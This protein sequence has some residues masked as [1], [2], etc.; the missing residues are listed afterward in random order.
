MLPK[1]NKLDFTGQTIYA[2]L[3]VHNKDFKVTILGENLSH[4][5]FTQPPKANVLANYLQK[6]FPGA[7]YYAAYE[8]GFSGFWLQEQLTSYGINCIVVNPAD[9]PTTDKEKKQKQDK[10]DSRKIARSLRNNDLE[11]IYVPSKEG[12]LDRS[13]VRVRQNIRSNLTR[14]KNRIKSML[15]YYGIEWPVR[16]ER[17]GT[18]WSKR[19]MAWL[20]EIDLGNEPGNASL[21]TYITEAHFL[22][23]LLLDTT[24]KVN[25]LSRT[26]KYKKQVILLLTVPGIGRLTAMIIL[27]EL[28]DITRFKNQDS[29]YAY[30]GLIPNMHSTG[31]NEN[32]GQMTKR[33]NGVLKSSLIESA[34]TAARKD[35]ALMMKYN[36][37]CQRMKA[38][39][40]IIRIT[41]K[42]ISRICYVLKHQKVYQIGVVS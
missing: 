30:I 33:G 8:A 9:I 20:E 12:Q 4:K 40:A 25:V 24:R 11:A 28:G 1:D 19:F 3:D 42:L 14:C 36:E 13:L 2:G 6:N 29:L 41:R 32:T 38:N 26:E 34:W 23:Q 7:N 37:L 18:H 31:D 27:T 22:R 16:F 10:R 21:H 17:N 15:Y 5:T 35:P 39:K